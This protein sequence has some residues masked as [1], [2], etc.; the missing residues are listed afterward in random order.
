MKFKTSAIALAVAGVVATPMAAQADIYASA[1]IGVENVL[2]MYRI[3]VCA[4]SVHVS[5]LAAKLISV[6]A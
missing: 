5:A 2:A 4:A 3:C 1:R 6:T